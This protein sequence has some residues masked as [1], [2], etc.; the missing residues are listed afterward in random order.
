MVQS[1]E[2]AVHVSNVNGEDLIVW[3]EAL[4]N[5]GGMSLNDCLQ[6]I[7]PKCDKRNSSKMVQSN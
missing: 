2:P 3:D 6:D 5:L 1:E 4:P 7:V